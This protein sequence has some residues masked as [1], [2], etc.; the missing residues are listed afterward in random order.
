MTP[1]G[2]V[3][4]AAG[5]VLERFAGRQRRLLADDAGPADL[6]DVAGAV[7]DDPVAGQQLHGVGASF[8][9]VTV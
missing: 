4:R 1:N 8:E 6:L 3:E 9:I 5:R 2:V 7:G